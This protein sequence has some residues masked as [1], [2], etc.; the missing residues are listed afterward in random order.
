MAHDRRPLIL[1]YHAVDSAWASP[2]AVT[3]RSLEL[4]AAY[5]AARG[6]IGLT[7]TEAERGRQLGRLPARSVV[8]TFDDGY[9]STALAAPILARFGFPATVFAVT[10]YVESQRPFD[11]YGVG[12]EDP[13]QL[14]PMDWDELAALKDK[15]WEVGSHT[16]THA[17][18]T[19]TDDR[20]LADELAGSRTRIV[21]RLGSCDSIAYPYGQA[22]RRVALAAGRAGYRAAV[23]LTGVVVADEALRRPRVGLGSGDRGLR[24]R[25]KLSAPGLAARRARPARL[26]RRWRGA[27]DWMPSD[28]PAAD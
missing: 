28:E 27:R 19:T 23:M 9:R 5:L 25:M 4:Q 10:G 21:E 13:A 3:A 7:V 26:V 24:L 1:A 12:H 11:W 14:S 15:G 17:L 20:T 8:F 16:V 2:L 22:D 18:L 6:F